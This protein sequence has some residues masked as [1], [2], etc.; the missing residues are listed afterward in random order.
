[1]LKKLLS[2]TGILALALSAAPALA[3]GDM[4]PPVV[5]GIS[6]P[7]FS[8][9]GVPV[10]IT[11]SYTDNLGVTG[12]VLQVNGG[13][14]GPMQISGSQTGTATISYAFGSGSD[15]YYVTVE[16][17]DAA[18][19]LGNKTGQ[20]TIS[21]NTGTGTLPT[22]TTDRLVKLVCPSGRVIDVND[23]CKA[24]YFVGRDGKRHAFPNEKVYFTWY[25][26][27]GGVIELSSSDLAAIPLGVNVTY[28]PGA[29]LVKFPSANQVYV[30]TRGGVLR[31]VKSEAVAMALYGA[32]WNKKVDDISEAFYANYKFGA[33]VNASSDYNAA[34][35][36]SVTNISDDL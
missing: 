10:N 23:P 30:V 7:S 9:P 21:D 18:G 12:C 2:M 35:E 24:V 17:S 31:A 33:D 15:Y 27:F 13:L 20:I 36:T 25:T 16:C 11:A 6:M 22:G 19:N 5:T 34:S 3:D 4:D 29:R 1:M 32:D 28:K 8:P 14:I 26:N